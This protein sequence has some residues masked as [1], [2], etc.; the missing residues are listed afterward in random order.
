MGTDIDFAAGPQGDQEK[1]T[2]TTVDDDTTID[3][4]IAAP[5]NATANATIDDVI[6]APDNATATAN[7]SDVDAASDA[8]ADPDAITADTANE[9]VLGSKTGRRKLQISVGGLFRDLDGDIAK[10][11]STLGPKAL[12][13][14]GPPLDV[15]AGV[16][17]AFH[18]DNYVPINLPHFGR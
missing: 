8:D 10:G 5:D 11:A 9:D 7:A 14:N 1:A 13:P 15:A 2:E 12:F 17:H 3:D 16:Q 18:H 4:V 6:A